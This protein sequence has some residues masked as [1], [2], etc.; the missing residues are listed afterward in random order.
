MMAL[1]QGKAKTTLG[2]IQLYHLVK[3]WGLGVLG[4]NPSL[5]DVLRMQRMD[6]VDRIFMLH[7][8]PKNWKDFSQADWRIIRRALTDD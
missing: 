8:N 5:V 7:N 2:E 4:P 3:R 1:A 6:H